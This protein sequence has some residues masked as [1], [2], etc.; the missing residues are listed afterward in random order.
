MRDSTGLTLVAMGSQHPLASVALKLTH[1]NQSLSMHA[2]F[3]E[4]LSRPRMFSSMMIV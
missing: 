1:H 4:A 2:L 3:V